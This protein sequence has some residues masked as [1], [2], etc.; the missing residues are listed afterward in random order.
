LFVEGKKAVCR[1][2]GLR[3]VLAGSF[4]WLLLLFCVSMCVGILLYAYAFAGCEP[5]HFVPF[6][7]PVYSFSFHVRRLTFA[8][9]R[10]VSCYPFAV[11][12]CLPL[13]P[14]LR[15][16]P[17]SVCHFAPPGRRLPLSV[18][19]RCRYLPFCVLTFAVHRSAFLAFSRSPFPVIRL[20][21][22]VVYRHLSFCV[23]RPPSACRFAPFS[24]VPRFTFPLLRVCRIAVAVSRFPFPASRF[25]FRFPL[26]LRFG[27]VVV[28]CRVYRLLVCRLLVSVS[29]L[30]FIV[31]RLS[32]DGFWLLVSV[33]RFPFRV[34]RLSFVV[35]RLTVVVCWFPFPVFRF[36][37]IVCRCRLSLS[38]DVVVLGF[39]FII[40][41]LSLTVVTV[42]A[43]L[44]LAAPPYRIAALF[45][46]VVALFPRFPVLSPVSRLFP[47]LSLRFPP[48]SRR[49]PSVLVPVF[50]RVSRFTYRVSCVKVAFLRVLRAFPLAIK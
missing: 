39:P 17:P 27:L 34:C 3:G 4:K 31:C 1:E 28:V 19:R 33:S 44:P 47:S 37:L 32:F 7:V 5:F 8:V 24:P 30:S 13:S 26:S 15:F 43:S 40:C 50:S 20:P 35:C 10:A 6:A 48:V 42:V 25:P 21:F 16:R 14:V 18:C 11:C 23:L 45:F 49:F 12:R 38:V 41:R 22:A 2:E 9:P 46:R 36:A 29:R